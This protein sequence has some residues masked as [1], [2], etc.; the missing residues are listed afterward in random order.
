MPHALRAICLAVLLLLPA[1]FVLSQSASDSGATGVR[2]TFPLARFN[3]TLFT[4][5]DAGFRVRF[6]GEGDVW[7]TTEGGLVRVEPETA[8]RQ[9][10]TSV[11]GLPS[12]YSLGLAIRGDDVYVGTDG[13]LA[14]VDRA[15]GEV[16]E[17]IDT[18]NS[19]LPDTIV[20]D[21]HFVG[22][23]LWVGTRFGGVAVWNVTKPAGDASA[24]EI[25]NTSTKV[26]YPKPVRRITSTPSSVWV[27]TEGDGAWRYDRA[28][29]EWNVTLKA[30]GLPTSEVTVVA[31][32]GTSVWFGTTKGLAERNA[33][34]EYR[35]YNTT[36]GM[37]D[38]RVSDVDML[39]TTNGTLDVFAA[40]AKGLWQLNPDTGGNATRAQSFGILGTR[41]FDHEFAPGKGWLFAT[42]RGVSYR[43]GEGGWQYYSTGPTTGRSWGP[44]H[45][46]FTSASVS[47][48]PGALFFG[49][50][51]GASA[52]RL[53]TEDR[54][55]SW[56]NFGSW[57]NYPGGVINWIDSEGNTTWFATS[58]GVYGLDFDQ[59]RWVP[60]TVPGIVNNVYSIEV[61]RGELWMALFGEGLRMENLTTGVVR[62]WSYDTLPTPLQDELLTD[63]R[64]DP[65]TDTMWIGGR[66]GLMKMDRTTGI[67]SATY[68]GADG[69]PGSGVIFRTEPDGPIVWLGTSNGGVAKFDVASG[70]VGRVW[71]A[72]NNPGFP[73]GEVRSL[74]REG[75]RLWVGT[76]EGLAQ[77]DITTNAFRAWNQTN[78]DLVQNHVN[79]IASAGGLLYVATLSGVQR[80]EIATG[81]FLPMRDGP[82]IIRGAVDTGSAGT[83]TRV[84]VRIDSPRDGIGVTG[85]EQVRGTA[86]AFGS[87][88]E[89]V[90]VR[91][92]TGG[93]QRATGTESWTFDWDTSAHPAGEPIALAARAFA[94][95]VS[96]EHE[97][98]VTPL[99][100]P[101][102]PLAIEEATPPTVAYANRSLR[103]AARAEGDE[104][105]TV[106]LYY[107]APGAGSYTRLALDRAGGLFTGSIPARDMREGD[108]RYYFEA[109]S[110]LL[111]DTA[112]GSADAPTLLDVQPAPRLAVSV[113]GPLELA[114]RAGEETRF[115]LN[116]TNSG[117][118]PATFRLSAS[119]LRSSW[120]YVPPEDLALGAGETRPVNA[121][122]TVPGGAFDDNTT[123]TFEARDTTGTA[124]PASAHVPVRILANG[125][126]PTKDDGEGRKGSLIP[127]PAFLLVA[128]LAAAASL[129]RRRA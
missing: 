59:N 55:G 21:L 45:Y 92:G 108:L 24:W 106:T 128:A 36:H 54:P 67:V 2:V 83:A 60:K 125:D 34:G 47:S 71:N 74:H 113:E 18:L 98:L 75:G 117:T 73:A 79:G 63:I 76:E 46:H 50:V 94:G 89:R 65:L 115:T 53:P 14:V 17:G 16:R 78:S 121:T 35:V 72:T 84:S 80:V 20:Q 112:S 39:P 23:E 116:V 56:V 99:A 81:E 88:I 51:G 90:E 4:A 86:L 118:E 9:L 33:A 68:T 123:L 37:P 100:P 42:S 15:T 26:D 91:I 111:V 87:D 7:Y 22:D 82:G 105:L 96:G 52:Y 25:K 32:R 103:L 43:N 11:E 19:P 119:G 28:T 69:I 104:P 6:D 122:I 5:V 29:G 66:I 97:V 101:T 77:I 30:N 31:E 58:A 57:A 120:L 64:A 70:K 126:G 10:I 124:D 85:V 61:D 109:Q 62:T 114:A 12:S 44:L 110:G 95:S 49:T 40:T 41:F 1:G 107:K 3:D 129:R 38:A 13:G 8:T 48:P 127:L 93:W 102:I 27:A